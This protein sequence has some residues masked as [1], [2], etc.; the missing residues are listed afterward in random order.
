MSV[1][2]DIPTKETPGYAYR[3][4]KGQMV[5]FAHA[6]RSQE[7]NIQRGTFTPTPRSD[8]RAVRLPQDPPGLRVT[9]TGPGEQGALTELPCPVS[10]AAPEAFPGPDT[11]VPITQDHTAR[12]AGA[13]CRSQA[14]LEGER[15]GGRGGE[16]SA[17][18]CAA[19]G[20]AQG[21]F[22]EPV[23]GGP[24]RGQAAEMVAGVRGPGPPSATSSGAHMCR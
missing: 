4:V 19:T 23:P 2:G 16:R 15:A 7:R 21:L 6:S 17:G 8:T 14:C 9:G 22:W 3:V 11:R 13:C 24:W 18:P 10:R 12:D 1:C 5:R 20:P